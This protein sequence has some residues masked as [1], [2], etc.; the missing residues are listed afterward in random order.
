LD[1]AAET[2]VDGLEDRLYREPILA[3][4]FFGC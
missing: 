3:G 4:N 2:V 1:I